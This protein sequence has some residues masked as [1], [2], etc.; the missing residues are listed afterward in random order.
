CLAL[1]YVCISLERS[2][3]LRSGLVGSLALPGFWWRFGLLGPTT[4]TLGFGNY[5]KWRRKTPHSISELTNSGRAAT[6]LA[7]SEYAF[8]RQLYVCRLVL[9][10]QFGLLACGCVM[11]V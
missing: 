10:Y 4:I 9:F 11:S 7:R 3:L 2:V 1:R 8:Q 6:L 5:V